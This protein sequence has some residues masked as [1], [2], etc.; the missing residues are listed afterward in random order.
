MHNATR[1]PR[2]RYAAGHHLIKPV[3]FD[4]L[5]ESLHELEGKHP[6]CA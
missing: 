4:A 3:D 5:N 6:A 1:A 2:G